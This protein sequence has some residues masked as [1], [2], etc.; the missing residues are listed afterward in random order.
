MNIIPLEYVAGLFDGEGWVT[1]TRHKPYTQYGQKSIVYTSRVSIEMT[2]TQ[3]LE[4]LHNQFGGSLSKRKKARA[5]NRKITHIWYLHGKNARDFL[6]MIL[7]FLRTK[8]EQAKIF[9]EYINHTSEYRNENPCRS[10]VI[11][12]DSLGF[13]EDCVQRIRKINGFQASRI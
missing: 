7:P 4:D 5:T 10:K 6:I 13:R 12:Q 9:I 2:D 11:S 3:L 8:K 1:I